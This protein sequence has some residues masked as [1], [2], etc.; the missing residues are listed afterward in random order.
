[1]KEV[2]LS[3]IPL[4]NENAVSQSYLSDMTGYK[5]REIR[6]IVNE[7]RKEYPV[8]SGNDGYWIG[9]NVD[10]NNT[11]NLLQ[12]HIKTMQ[13]TVDNLE[14]ILDIMEE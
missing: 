10:I 5:K 12:S 14:R 2:I 11:I 7:L 9:N 3:L 6:L 4:G 1:M 8:C 13:E